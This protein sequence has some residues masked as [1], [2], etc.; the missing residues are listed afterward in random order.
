MMY[1]VETLAKADAIVF[2]TNMLLK[3]VMVCDN[4]DKVGIPALLTYTVIEN[5]PESKF[6]LCDEFKVL[7]PGDY[8]EQAREM[9]ECEPVWA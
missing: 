6:R 8:F 4:F 7:V 5:D 2:S 1:P 3:A 9:L